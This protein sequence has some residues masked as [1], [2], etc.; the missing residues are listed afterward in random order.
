MDIFQAVADLDGD[1]V[2][3]AEVVRLAEGEAAVIVLVRSMLE[4]DHT[5][6]LTGA[7]TGAGLVQQLAREI[8]ATE[9]PSAPEHI[10]GYRLIE[11]LGAG[12]MGTVYLAEQERPQRLVA[13][14]VLHP[15]LRS[16]VGTARF[17]FEAMALARVGHPN[18]PTVYEAGETNGAP[19]IAMELVRGEPLHVHARQQALSGMARAAL[20]VQLAD[21]VQAAHDVGLV[22]RDIKPHNLLVTARGV[23]KILDF[24]VSAGVEEQD[25][26]LR[27]RVGTR[28]WSSPEQLEGSAVTAR[29]DIYALGVV[30]SALLVRHE[31]EPT[32]AV[33][34]VPL[35]ASALLADLPPDVA[36]V[37]ARSVA[38]DPADRYPTAAAFADDLGRALRFEPVQAVRPT[39]PYLARRW[40]Q[41]N[42]RVARAAA[43][44]AAVGLVSTAVV[45]V[46]GRLDEAARSR[47]ADAMVE[48]ELQRLGPDIEVAS[49]LIDLASRSEVQGTDA[50][51]E[52]LVQAGRLASRGAAWELE[53]DALSTAYADA[54]DER[55]RA[56][57]TAALVVA[58]ADRWRWSDA[59][60]A[61]LLLERHRGRALL[62]V[63]ERARVLVGAGQLG[64]A[65]DLLPA[66]ALILPLLRQLQRR[67]A[68][69]H[70]ALPMTVSAV[71]EEAGPD[72]FLLDRQR[73]QVVRVARTPGLEVREHLDTGPIKLGWPRTD[74]VLWDGPHAVA[75]DRQ[76]PELLTLWRLQATGPP[77]PVHSWPDHS[78]SRVKVAQIGG[79]QPEILVATAA[80]SRHLVGLRP[81]AEGWSHRSP[82]PS[83]D[84]FGSDLQDIEAA[85]LDRDGRD[86][87][88]VAFGPWNAYGVHLATEEGGQLVSRD[89]ATLGFVNELVTLQTP[90]GPRMVALKSNRYAHPWLLGEGR[91]FGREP[92]LYLLGLKDGR[93]HEEAFLDAVVP[94]GGQDEVGMV[95]GWAGDVDGDGLEDLAIWV[96]TDEAS[97]TWL[98]RQLPEGGFAELLIAGVRVVGVEDLDAD[99]EGELLVVETAPGAPTHPELIVLGA[100]ELAADPPIDVA[101]PDPVV[102][103]DR[104]LERTWTSAE[105]LAALGLGDRAAPLL[106]AA[107]Q[108]ARDPDGAARGLRRAADLYERHGSSDAALRAL[109]AAVDRSPAGS[110]LWRACLEHLHEVSL[111][112]ALPE[113][114]AA[115][116]SKLAEVD[117][118]WPYE[119]ERLGA[120]TDP[121][122]RFA[123]PDRAEPLPWE[124][125][126]PELVHS[127]VNGGLELHA[128]NQQVVLV[129]RGIATESG[130]LRLEVELD[131]VDFEPAAA[132]LLRVVS[133]A[134]VVGQL[135]LSAQSSS[136]PA[137]S[138]LLGCSTGDGAADVSAS[139][140]VVAT[141]GPISLE[142]DLIDQFGRCAIRQGA[143]RDEVRFQVPRE[144]AA[145][146]AIEILG[147]GSAAYQSEAAVIGTAR[148]TRLVVLP[149]RALPLVDD[150]VHRAHRALAMG[151]FV[152]EVDAR[153]PPQ[154]AAL[155]ALREGR[156]DRAAASL[157]KMPWTDETRAFVRRLLRVEG[158]LAERAVTLAWPS[159]GW[160]LLIETRTAAAAD[161]DATEVLRLL[162]HPRI[163]SGALATEAAVN[164][165]YLRARAL[166]ETAAFQRAEQEL[167]VLVAAIE[168]LSLQGPLASDV[169]ECLAVAL[170]RQGKVKEAGTWLAA[171]RAHGAL[172]DV[173][174]ARQNRREDLA[175]ILRAVEEGG[176]GA[177]GPA[178]QVDG[179]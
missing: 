60:A 126:L 59:H 77:V 98:L 122:R 121:G 84:R 32:S 19:W 178:Q 9:P 91:S 56:R 155:V 11:A 71:A 95:H 101:S 3:A 133:E 12:G 124:V 10:D 85:D 119:A 63:G 99:G 78:E 137:S 141:A 160:T 68:T 135:Q 174:R 69:G 51:V 116:A 172:P 93:L 164:L 161:A 167:R 153:L 177:E 76:D 22:H 106:E 15:W 42:R 168:V 132:V 123:I 147:A 7:P 131:D 112:A 80:Y 100:G 151:E 139:A 145:G 13:L 166:V 159:E 73:N 170:F 110:T 67:T 66:D 34:S 72:L 162:D 144:P 107:A 154:T 20:V 128:P 75:Q 70:T 120:L 26:V 97:N 53:L 134:G 55:G 27:Q 136:A 36:P 74:L 25:E 29:A 14:K 171:A 149:A 103:T 33:P 114:A 47:A 44:L 157:R 6:C 41:R 87:L 140:M 46:Q 81:G 40:L 111:A 64:A 38:A 39:L 102:T 58:L 156:P 113:L 92:G 163:L 90:A 179:G 17:R 2:R 4:H 18:I 152:G 79:G 43:M 82:G 105:T 138:W 143:A 1:E 130:R 62:P 88:F 61:L 86:E 16:E 8:A 57:A 83:I 24:G 129:R 52:A 118:G 176:L 49:R 115:A 108:R 150:A 146:V 109:Q 65:A 28:G 158:E 104:E 175:E 31:G 54:H 173:M 127:A 117:E 89:H 142:L 96:D 165:R 37:L 21:A 5:G 125:E 94:V 30:A 148:L 23:P 48:A 169:L 45:F 50:A 35:P